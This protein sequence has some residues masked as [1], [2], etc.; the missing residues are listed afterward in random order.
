MLSG[1]PGTNCKQKGGPTRNDVLPS[2]FRPA[3]AKGGEPGE[4]RCPACLPR[5]A[6]DRRSGLR[7]GQE[8]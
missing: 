7:G 3:E 1:G 6:D 4:G 2:E 8:L 5:A